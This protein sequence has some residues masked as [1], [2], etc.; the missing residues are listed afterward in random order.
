[1]PRVVNM[2]NNM[3]V[4]KVTVCVITYNQED[5]IAD[6]LQSIV[7][8]V[9]DFTFEVVVSDDGSKDRT[10]AIIR[11]Y[12][13]KYPDLI[14]PIFHKDNFGLPTKN[15]LC[16][17]NEA[18]G[19]YIAHID[20]DDLMLPG[21]LQS[22][23]DFLDA[24]PDYSVV[25]HRVFSFSDKNTNFILNDIG[26]EGAGFTTYNLRDIAKFGNVSTHSSTMYR[27]EVRVTR[28]SNIDI[29]DSEFYI[30][31]L[32]KGKAAVLDKVLGCYRYK[33]GE[34]LSSKKISRKNQK[35]RADFLMRVYCKYPGLRKEL[36]L[37]GLLQVLVSLRHCQLPCSADVILLYKLFVLVSPYEL[38]IYYKNIKRIMSI[39]ILSI[40]E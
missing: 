9:V 16:A 19:K 25:W 29:Y 14:V 27:S 21:K 15:F 12:K 10:A 2:D 5:Y 33:Y 34:T 32:E 39:N 17:H 36:F 7:D 23:V 8:Q 1:M 24:H 3:I 31:Y 6:C 20:G 26:D 38:Y 4:P 35:L 30:E 22:Q 18:K 11:E 28:T 37:R 40:P 13:E